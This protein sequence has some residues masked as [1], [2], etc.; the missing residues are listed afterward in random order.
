MADIFNF[1]FAIVIIVVVLI[2]P[3]KKTPKFE[4]NV[5]DKLDLPILGRGVNT[6][7]VC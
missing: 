5:P 3:I 4:V 7:A 1:A 6:P 2:R